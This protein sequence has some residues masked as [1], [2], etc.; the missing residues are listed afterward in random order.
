M[1]NISNKRDFPKITKNH[2][3]HEKPDFRNC[4]NLFPQ[5]THKLSIRKKIVSHASLFSAKIVFVY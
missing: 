1:F 3:Q 5:N 4:I 2:T